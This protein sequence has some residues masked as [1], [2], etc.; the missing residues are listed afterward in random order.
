MSCK[1][2]AEALRD[3]DRQELEGRGD[4]PLARHVTRCDA[5]RARAEA[6]LAGTDR[7][8]RALDE[9]AGLRPGPASPAVDDR[10]AARRAMAAARTRIDDD[11][12]PASRNDRGFHPGKR[13]GGRD[14][15]WLRSAVPLAAAAVLALVYA[16]GEPPPPPGGWEAPSPT[17][18]A[19]PPSSPSVE[20]G[21]GAGTV[22]V[23]ETSDPDITVVWFFQEE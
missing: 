2:A 12:K 6:I 15:S 13:P 20:P 10:E 5:C 18:P 11:R 7:L 4:T 22:A 19:T 3:A 8:G 14:R 16:I 1:R 23:F 17:V 21:E 9:L